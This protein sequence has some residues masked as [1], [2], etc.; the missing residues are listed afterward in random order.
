[1]GVASMV[2]GIVSLAIGFFP[3]CGAW[4]VIPAVVGLG[5]GI[6]DLI[7]KTMRKESRA[8]A[9][10][11][12]VLNPAAILIIVGYFVMAD[13]QMQDQW[14]Q[15]IDAW[16]AGPSPFGQQPGPP[17]WPG[18]PGQPGQPGG[19]P[20]QPLQPM[21]PMQP[22]QPVDTAAPPEPDTSTAEPEPVPVR[23]PAPPAPSP[24]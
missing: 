14:P 6:A 23:P 19:V 12:V 18:Q 8:K 21:Q 2:I 5:L 10:V 24:P 1:M 11:G 7:V 17:G 15:P 20:G 9:I 3:L 4:A 22:M 16:D 13:V